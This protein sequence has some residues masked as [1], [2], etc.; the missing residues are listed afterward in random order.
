MEKVT[1]RRI[2]RNLVPYFFLREKERAG[3]WFVKMRFV[4][5]RLNII[6]IRL[7]INKFRYEK[8]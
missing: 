1:R 6:R 7:Y 5:I 3:W 4:M 8:E 2:W